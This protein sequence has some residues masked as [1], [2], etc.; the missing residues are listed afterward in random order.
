MKNIPFIRK[1]KHAIKADQRDASDVFKKIRQ[2]GSIKHVDKLFGDMGVIEASSIIGSLLGNKKK[3]SESLRRFKRFFKLCKSLG[4]AAKKQGKFVRISDI[5]RCIFP[6]GP[7]SDTDPRNI[8]FYSKYK[9]VITSAKTRER[10]EISETEESLRTKIIS[11]H[12]STDQRLFGDIQ[13]IQIIK[14]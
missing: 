9:V 12:S 5:Y 3:D 8:K 1:V 6:F 13:D 4:K 10:I 14:L 7:Y 11:R 2:H